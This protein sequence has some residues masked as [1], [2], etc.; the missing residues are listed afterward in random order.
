MRAEVQQYLRTI[1]CPNCKGNLAEAPSGLVC[2]QCDY[3][4][5]RNSYGYFELLV[6]GTGQI[7]RGPSETYATIQESSGVLRYEKYLKPI[8]SSEPCRTLLDVG[9]GLGKG[10]SSML[11]DGYE[12]YG[13][14][15]P[16]LSKFWS[17]VSNDTNHFFC[18][19]ATH[20]PFRNDFFDAVWSS[21]VIEHIGTAGDLFTLSGDYQELRRAYAREILRVTKPGG[22]I[23]ID[24]PNK[25]FPIDLCHGLI[26]DSSGRSA[27]NRLR[28][29]IFRATRM[30]IHPVAGKYYLLSYRETKRLFCNEEGARFFEPLPLRGYFAFAVFRSGFLKPFGKLAKIYVEQLPRIFRGTP[31]N[32]WMSVLIRK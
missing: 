7:S 1:V 29:F 27:L 9:C 21:G 3:V 17:Q 26:A 15:L 16:I 30:N 25:S 10:V 6:P 2:K 13:I 4:F 19:D 24:C 14:D 11:K 5:P 18:C 12:A 8:L 31:L 20:L 22:R 23:I 32:P 28:S